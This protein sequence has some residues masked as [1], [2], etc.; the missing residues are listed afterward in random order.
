MSQ[1]EQI[2]TKWQQFW[3][4]HKIFE[5]QIDTSKESFFITVAYPY[6]NSV[7]HIGHGRTFTMADILAR[8]QRL[9][10]K[11]VL[12]PMGFHITGTPVLAVS[13]AIAQNDEIQIQSTKS[14]IATFI[15][16]EDE[17]LKTLKSF[18][19]PYNIANFFSSKISLTFD[20]VGLSIDWSRCFTTGDEIYNSF[21][22]WQFEKLHENGM[23]KQGSYPILYSPIDENAVGE[24]DIKDG[25]VDKVTIQEMVYILF[26]DTKRDEYISVATLRPDAL[27]GTT[28]VW[29][30]PN[31]NLLKV[32]VKDKIWI[33]SKPAYEKIKHQFQNTKIESEI[34]GEELLGRTYSTPFINR[35]VPIASASFIDSNHGT[36]MVYSSPAGSPHDYMGVVQARNDGRLPKDLQII[37]TVITKDKKG[38]IIHWNGEC[39]AHHMVTKYGITSID[40][41]KLEDAKQALYKLE[42]YGGVLNELC[43]EWKNIPIKHA[44]EKITQALVDAKLGGIFYDTSRRAVTR[45][46]KPVIVAVLQG[47]WFLDYTHPDVK[48][49]AHA[50]LNQL[51]YKPQNLRKTQQEYLDWVAMRPCARK[52]GL[53]TKLPFD[54]EWVIESLSDSTI[55]QMFYLVANTLHKHTVSAK[56]LTP[57]FYDYVF[58]HKG[59]VDSKL[60]KIADEI[61]QEISYW[62]HVDVRYTNKPHMSNHLSFLLYHYG[63][64]FNKDQWPKNIT[65]GG[66]LIKD[67]HK[68][69]KSKG[70]G[71]PLNTIKSVYGADLYRLYVGVGANY[72]VDM[73]FKDSEIIQL[74]KKFSRLIQ[75]CEDAVQKPLRNYDSFTQIDKWLISR[76][77]SHVDSYFTHMDSVKIREAYVA[78]VYECLNDC[79]HH[80]NQ[81]NASQTAEVMRFFIL[82][83]LRVLTPIIPHVCEELNE[84]LGNKTCISVQKYDTDN[85]KFQDRKLEAKEAIGQS[86]LAQIQR[87]S[88]QKN[89]SKIQ[90]ITIVQ[91]HKQR[92]VLF[93]KIS[94]ILTQTKNFKE[95]LPPLLTEFSNDAK[96]IKRFVPKTLSEGLQ[97]FESQEDEQKYLESFGKYLQTLYDCDI[98]IQTSD[99][100]SFIIPGKPGILIE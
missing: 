80:I 75:F 46:Q 66:L 31:E 2:E 38:Q 16:D 64:I 83:Y 7:M 12:Y 51:E 50:V 93:T 61:Q 19:D 8:Y 55:Y 14:A 22:E 1:N 35:E 84:K 26:K 69:S 100:Q 71:I 40:D 29:V 96:F 9:K 79:M 89:I 68:I 60:Q 98:K 81:T 97:F 5:P 21:I 32:N 30:N 34:R 82:D 28:N 70:N 10:G 11:N 57:A 67:G 74:Q 62:K 78:I 88:E 56:S 24:D 25:D 47:Q 90:K 73:D 42:H 77:Y 20:S 43:G 59:S 41:E 48:A 92:F 36:G 27:F 23:V 53:G 54:K 63:V 37:Q 85:A 72:D 4:E 15:K 3:K 6:A 94:D 99:L 39:A 45:S 44:K 87:I 65:I 18:T 17:Q 86:L 58:F 76:F 49:K 13:D 52:R 95:V 91:A 33:V